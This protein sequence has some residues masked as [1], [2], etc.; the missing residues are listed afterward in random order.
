MRD[1]LGRVLAKLPP[2]LRND[3]DVERLAIACNQGNVSLVHLINRR[4]SHAASSKDYEFSR[5]TMEEH[6]ESGYS[7]MQHTLRH[8]E[9]LQRPQSADGVFTF[10]LAVQ[11]R[12]SKEATK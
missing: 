10:D 5:R 12:K 3:P 1:A 2:A 6:W 7:D 4:L 11:G 9:V 8:P